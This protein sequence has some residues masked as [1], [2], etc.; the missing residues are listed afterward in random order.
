[1]NFIARGS[2]GW[3]LPLLAVLPTSF[4]PILLLPQRRASPAS[5]PTP[6]HRYDGGGRPRT[7]AAECRER[8]DHVCLGGNLMVTEQLGGEQVLARAHRKADIRVA[9]VNPELSLATAPGSTCG[10]LEN[11]QPF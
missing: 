3:G 8:G 2:G 11:L 5:A 4:V 7:Y 1:M 10:P 9:G 6:P